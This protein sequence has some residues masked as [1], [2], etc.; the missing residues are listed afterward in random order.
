MGCVPHVSGHRRKKY[1]KW[2]R[3]TSPKVAWNFLS[4]PRVTTVVG[5]N[6]VVGSEA[7]KVG[8]SEV[9]NWEGSESGS[10]QNRSPEP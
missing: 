4:T 9:E 2:G 3:M 10:F 6:C 7:R 8:S 5:D 1:M